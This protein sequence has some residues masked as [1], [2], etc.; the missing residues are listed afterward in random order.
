MF[1]NRTKKKIINLIKKHEGNSKIKMNTDKEENKQKRWDFSLQ[2]RNSGGLA[3]RNNLIQA[4]R[5]LRSREIFGL[6]NSP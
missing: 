5:Y 3:K 6:H 2:K 1:K 4:A